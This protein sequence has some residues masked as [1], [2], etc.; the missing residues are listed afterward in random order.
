MRKVQ[1]ALENVAL[2]IPAVDASSGNKRA[3]LAC[4]TCAPDAGVSA[5][6]S[7]GQGREDEPACKKGDG[8]RCGQIHREVEDVFCAHGPRGGACLESEPDHLLSSPTMFKYE[9]MECEC[10]RARMDQSGPWKAQWTLHKC[11]ESIAI[12][13]ASIHVGPPFS[14]AASKPSVLLPCLA[15]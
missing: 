11:S 10:T 7:E 9:G 4:W 13:S 15:L 6:A 12:S 1:H 8:Q 14:A 2:A 5:V 3:Y